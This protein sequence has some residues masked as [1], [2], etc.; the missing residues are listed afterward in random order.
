[1]I[2]KL[3]LKF[4]KAPGLEP[5]SLSPN[6]IT[7]FVGPNNSGKSL[8]LR[9]ILQYCQNGS[10]NTRNMILDSIQFQGF[11]RDSVNQ[12]VGD[13]LL[14]PNFGEAIQPGHILVGKKGT[15]HQLPEEE[16]KRILEN[17]NT[18]H[19]QFCSWYL[20]YNTLFLDGQSRIGLIS[21][22]QA[23]DLQQQPHSSLQVLIRDNSRR[24]DIRR[25]IY[26]A[27]GR[28]FVVDPTN[29]GHLRIRLSDRAPDSTIEEI[30]IH[31]EAVSFHAAAQHINEASDGVKAFTGILTEVIAGDPNII[32]IDE[33][34]AFLHP[35]L[36][37]KLGL[38]LSKAT[39]GSDKKVFI[40][41]HSPNFV[42]GCIQSGVEVNIIRLT[43]KEKIPTARILS[44]ADI[45]RLMRS[46]LLR[47]TNVLSGLFFES[48]IVTESDSDR[49]FYQEINERLLRFCPEK[50]IQNALF[51][52]AQNKQT[53]PVIVKPLRDLGIAACGV[54]DIDMLKEGGTVFSTLLTSVSVPEISHSGMATIRA[55]IKAKCDASGL[56]MKKGGGVSI[57]SKDD[58]RAANDLFD[59]LAEYGLFVVRGGE[60]ESWLKALAATGHGSGW[61]IQM[62]EKMGE[63]P[64]KEAYLKP[65]TD[66]V[67]DFIFTI[68]QWLVN[69]KRKGIP[70]ET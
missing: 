42:M 45:L 59:Q 39:I 22:Q 28:Y 25:I 57:L 20:S 18:N 14:K 7:V 36:A 19:N 32:L 51:L 37:Y 63:D 35:A 31:P 4:G 49:A 53:V 46:P 48:V 12:K 15:R 66:D 38:E 40:S 21:D 65:G 30:G 33:P 10:Q 3:K 56:D 60:L 70:V 41:T 47:S 50:G 55:N 6:A 67:W 61:L 24:E 1:M 16:L 54:I 13:I 5:I 44:N 34:E 29:L 68:K 8:A 2:T 52:N 64:E 11:S 62:F 27:F 26:E 23:G 9:E 43:Y 58:S 69:P 17:P